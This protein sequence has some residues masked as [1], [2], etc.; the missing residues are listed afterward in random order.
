DHQELSKRIDAVTGARVVPAQR[1]RHRAARQHARQHQEQ[2]PHSAVSTPRNT[3]AGGPPTQFFVARCSLVSKTNA[4]SAKR[5]VRRDN[6]SVPSAFAVSQTPRSKL[7]EALEGYGLVD[8]RWSPPN[9][10]SF[11]AAATNPPP[12]ARF[13]QP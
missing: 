4:A 13:P 12:A 5:C 7:W 10:L 11:V 2:S 8:A 3:M 9:R 1:R 6:L